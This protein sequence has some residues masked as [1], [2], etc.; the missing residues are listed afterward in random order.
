L[1]PDTEL[2][3]RVHGLSQFPVRARFESFGPAQ[4]RRRA[5]RLVLPLVL[6]SVVVLPIPGF[7]LSIPFLLGSA[8]WVGRRR[9]RETEQL[10]ELVGECPCGRGPQPYAL[11][12]RVALPL[13]LRCP[14]CREFVRVE[15]AGSCADGKERCET[16]K[17]L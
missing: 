17:V 5:L 15:S 1:T 10:R 11:P 14:A 2:C 13:L 16:S 9:L 6:L 4:R 8:F 3:G 7:H 12:D